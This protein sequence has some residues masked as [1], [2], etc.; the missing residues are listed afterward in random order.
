MRVALKCSIPSSDFAASDSLAT[1]GSA[2]VRLYPM[3]NRF[4]G[5]DPA[6]LLAEMELA[7]GLTFEGF[8]LVKASGR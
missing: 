6:D 3:E 1:G 5:V 8:R 4:D 2:A 7:S